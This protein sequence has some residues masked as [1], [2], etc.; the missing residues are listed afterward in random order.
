MFCLKLVIPLV[1]NILVEIILVVI[2]LV[3]IDQDYS[4]D[5]IRYEGDFVPAE[6]NDVV[7]DDY[8]TTALVNIVS[9][10]AA[11]LVSSHC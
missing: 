5:K 8:V 1:V 9:Q 11:S 7:E 2:I 10:S 4:E 3:V 6:E